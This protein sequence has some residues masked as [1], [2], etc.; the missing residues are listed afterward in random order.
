MPTLDERLPPQGWLLYTNERYGFSLFFPEYLSVKERDHGQNSMTITFE[1]VERGEGFEIFVVPY[2]DAHVSEARFR[3][4]V[5]SGVR[6]N[7]VDVMVHN[8][9]AVAFFSKHDI[10]ETA[11]VWFVYRGHLYEVATL[12]EHSVWLGNILQSWQFTQY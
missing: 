4:D 12:K 8:V 5:P 9:P 1:N 11:E 10:G 3:Q 2:I 6:E 7:P